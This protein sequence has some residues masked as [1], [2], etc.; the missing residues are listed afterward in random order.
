[1]LFLNLR[2]LVFENWFRQKDIRVYCS[3]LFGSLVRSKWLLGAFDRFV[4]LDMG[5]FMLVGLMHIFL[6]PCYVLFRRCFVMFL[7]G[8]V[9]MLLC[10]I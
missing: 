1:M 2:M 10:D 5:L 6:L 4:P 3:T 9:L 7:L 8:I